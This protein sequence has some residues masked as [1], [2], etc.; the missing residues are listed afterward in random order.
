MRSA[1]VALGAFVLTACHQLPELTPN[2]CGNGVVEPGEDCDRF[3]QFGSD[4]ECGSE[5]R[6]TCNPKNPS[7]PGIRTCGRDGICRLPSGTYAESLDSPLTL[8]AFDLATA[9]LDHDGIEDLIG[10]SADRIEVRYGLG[11]GTYRE[12]FSIAIDTPLGERTLGDVDGDGIP[13]LLIPYYLGVEAFLGQSERRLIPVAHPQIVLEDLGGSGADD[14]RLLAARGAPF[15]VWLAGHRIHLAFDPGSVAESASPGTAIASA[16]VVQLSNDGDEEVLVLALEDSDRLWLGRVRG[17]STT[18]TATL[19]AHALGVYGTIDADGAR[20]VDLDGDGKND[21]L[22]S[23]RDGLDHHFVLFAGTGAGLAAPREEARL[24]TWPLAARGRNGSA[25]IVF[26]RAIVTSTAPGSA[27]V[28]IA[29]SGPTTWTHAAVADFDGD[30]MLD[31]VVADDRSAGAALM[32]RADAFTFNRV[33]LPLPAPAR[34]IA[35]GDFDGDRVDDLAAIVRTQDGTRLPTDDVYVVFAERSG[36]PGDPIFMAR[37]PEVTNLSASEFLSPTPWNPDRIADLLVEVTEP[38][39][40]QP[41]YASILVGSGRRRLQSPIPFFSATH[42]FGTPYLV[43]LGNFDAVPPGEPDLI[44]LTLEG[45]VW[46]IP[47]RDGSRFRL[48]GALV[49]DVEASTASDGLC[50]FRRAALQ[51]RCARLEVGDLVTGGP[52][53]AV[54]ADRSLSCAD[55]PGPPRVAVLALAAGKLTCTPVNATLI[56][57]RTALLRTELLDVDRDGHP[58]LVLAF[59]GD[60]PAISVAFGTGDDGDGFARTQ[61]IEIP[62]ESA[63]IDLTAVAGPQLAVLATGGLYVVKLG[64][65]SG[66]TVAAI[67]QIATRAISQSAGARVQAARIDDDGLEDLVVGVGDRVYIYLGGEGFS[68]GALTPK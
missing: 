9:D 17:R 67:D 60:R 55:D 3:S 56:G 57:D 6:Y 24:E 39:G 7:C 5:C 42:G 48:L 35:A 47:N 19:E 64:G 33:D 15:A 28:P 61:P 51:R 8:E 54:L 34:E 20:V 65:D 68:G 37:F 59:G 12:S 50:D 63:P 58:D 21:V 41:S 16:E 30:G 46:M 52:D 40:R 11:D 38:G 36:P 29:T 49:Q 22:V 18:A 2:S 31:A 32:Y 1:T 25:L 4:F 27:F 66:R 62:L 26:P 13:D 14:A 44:A 45:Q 43:R 10:G 23:A 53:E